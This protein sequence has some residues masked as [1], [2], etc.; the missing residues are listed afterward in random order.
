MNKTTAKIAYYGCFVVAIIITY[1]A[2]G[3]AGDLAYSGKQPL[4]WLSVLAFF[5]VVALVILA[6]M[7]KAKFKI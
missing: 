3:Y 2:M 1:R 6:I 4:V 7:I 5:A